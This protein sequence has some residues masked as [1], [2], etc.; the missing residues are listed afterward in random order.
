MSTTSPFGDEPKNTGSNGSSANIN[1]HR[2]HRERIHNSMIEA[3]KEMGTTAPAKR[4]TW[5]KAV[6]N[7]LRSIDGTY[8]LKSTQV[9]ND[10][11]VAPARRKPDSFTPRP[12]KHGTRHFTTPQ[13]NRGSV[14]AHAQVHSFRTPAR[15]QPHLARYSEFAQMQ[16]HARYSELAQMQPQEHASVYGQAQTSAYG[17]YQMDPVL[18]QGQARYTPAYERSSS[19][20]Q[21]NMPQV[22]RSLELKDPVLR[23]PHPL[24]VADRARTEP[25]TN[26]TTGFVASMTPQTQPPD[27]TDNDLQHQ[28]GEAGSK[29]D[30]ASD[31]SDQTEQKGTDA[32]QDYVPMASPAGETGENE[33]IKEM[34]REMRQENANRL[35]EMRQENANSRLREEE[36]RSQLANMQ[37]ELEMSQRQHALERSMS[38]DVEAE[39]ADG[40][41]QWMLNAELEADLQVD[42]LYYREDAKRL[43]DNVETRLRMRVYAHI[44][45]TVP[46]EFYSQLSYGD[47][48]GLYMSVKSLGSCD[49]AEQIMNLQMSVET[50]KKQGKPMSQWLDELYKLLE[51]LAV[52]DE[53]MELSRLRVYIMRNLQYDKRYERVATDVR[54][55]PGWDM[56]KIRQKLEAEAAY[57]KDLLPTA[58]NPRHQAHMGR[59]N[60]TELSEI[61]EVHAHYKALL[62]AQSAHPSGKPIGAAPAEGPTFTQAEIESHAATTCLDN[63]KGYCRRGDA[64]HRDHKMITGANLELVK[65]QVSLNYRNQKGG[66]GKGKG[67]GGKGRGGGGHDR[68]DAADS[69]S[70]CYSFGNNGVCSYGDNC[71]F[72]HDLPGAHVNMAKL[73]PV[74]AKPGDLIMIRMGCILQPLRG[75]MG[76]VASVIKNKAQ[77]AN[78]AQV[79]LILTDV[80]L[81]CSDKDRQMVEQWASMA[82]EIGITAAE[83]IICPKINAKVMLARNRA[84]ANDGGPYSLSGLFDTGAN[85]GISE[86]EKMIENLEALDELAIVD[87]LL[88]QVVATH[89]GFMSMKMGTDRVRFPCLLVKGSPHTIVPGK[90][91]GIGDYSFLGKDGGLQILKHD[92]IL[93]SFPRKMDMGS[94]SVYSEAFA[95]DIGTEGGEAYMHTLYPVPDSAFMTAAEAEQAP[96]YALVATR[97]QSLDLSVKT[98]GDSD[99]QQTKALGL[100][101]T[102]HQKTGHRSNEHNAFMHELITGK[103]ITQEEMRA[104]EPCVSCDIAKITSNPNQKERV[105]PLTKVG[106]DVATDMIVGMPRSL[107]GY[108]HAFHIHCM[109]SNY[110]TIIPLRTKDCG[111]HVMYWIKWLQ[112]RTGN[113]V[114][115]LHIDGGEAYTKKLAAFLADQGTEMVVNLANVHS[116]TTIERRHRDVNNIHNAQMHLGQAPSTLWEFSMPNA[117]HLINLNIPIRKLREMKKH[118]KALLRLT[119]RPLVPLEMVMGEINLRKIWSNLHTMFTLCVGKIETVY[120]EQHGAK[121]FQGVY[122]GT[123]QSSGNTTQYGHHMLRMHD[124]KVIAV[125]TVVT[126]ENTFPFAAKI[127]RTPTLPNPADSNSGGEELSVEYESAMDSIKGRIKAPEKFTPGTEAMTTA[128][129]CII[130]DRYDDGDYSATFPN[131][132]EPL[133]VRSVLAKDLWLAHEWPDWDHDSTGTRTSTEYTMT[134]TSALPT[135][136]RGTPH[137]HGRLSALAEAQAQL[138][139]IV[140]DE[141]NMDDEAKHNEGIGLRTT[142]SSTAKAAIKAAAKT[143]GSQYT[144][145]DPGRA[146]YVQPYNQQIKA[147]AMFTR[148]VLPEGT[149][150]QPTSASLKLQLACDVERILPK[151]WH[152]SHGHPYE[153]HLRKVEIKELQDCINRGVF[154]PPMDITPDMT[155]IGLMWVYAVKNDLGGL[156]TTFRARITLMGNQERLLIDK[157]MA[158]A[159]VAQSVMVRLL[160]VTHL[161]LPDIIFRQLDVSNAY[162]NEYMK[163]F[164]VC[165]MPPGYVIETAKDGSATFRTLRL[166]ERQPHQCCQVIKALYGGMECGR[167]FWESWV[168]WHLGRGFQIIHEERCYLHIRDGQGNWIKLCYHVDD[169]FIVAKGW[170]YYQAYL[171]DLSSKFDYTEGALESHLGVAYHHDPELG[172]MRIEQSAQT[173]KFLKEFKHDE[174]KPAA[175][176]TLA[177]P[178]P[179]KEDCLEPHVSEDAWD[180]E[181]FIGHANYLHMCTRPDIGQPLKIL[182]RFTKS[183]G[184][185]H[186]EYAKHL[187]RY[188][189][190]TVN[191]GLVYRTGYP[192]YYQIFTDASH[193]SCVDTR[194]SIISIVVKLGGNTVF[195][196]NSFTKI[197]SHSSTESELMALDV[198]ATIGQMLRWLVESIGGPVQGNIQIFVDNAGTISIASNPIQSGRNLHVHARYFYVRDLVYEDQFRIEKIPTELQ[199]ADIGCTFKGVK[200]FLDLRDCLLMCA[201]VIHDTNENPT[202]ET[203]Y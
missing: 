111:D 137:A 112:N 6:V 31:Q 46:K 19:L 65:Q 177:G 113:T 100:L 32:D 49:S 131:D 199:V 17:Q 128:G 170:D 85:I 105:I 135:G 164:V 37:A 179:C 184:K 161:H 159:P 58:P 142:R 38:Q 143:A 198:G 1:G 140:I 44:T 149:D 123:I 108:V 118:K 79:Q 186:V 99:T 23:T 53:P 47:V 63:I 151:H 155:I 174:C 25:R 28:G 26:I 129:P 156:F 62:L 152:Q 115:R 72:S 74:E 13:G 201:R 141:I 101:R 90:F 5:S 88:G 180:M 191:E 84:K 39:G 130:L 68:P 122:L 175:A 147:K 43:E 98:A 30:D 45:T 160:V 10:A 97:S 107:Q 21:L 8:M 36:T 165:R 9:S 24:G 59:H 48:L 93:A 194:R 154:G 116:N 153:Q 83:Y 34:F 77:G 87:A 27:H 71:K 127:Q 42:F 121:G 11:P 106:N 120:V 187:L 56:P 150:L 133:E 69:A 78:R 81:G 114:L 64:C 192:L 132:E 40:P 7:M 202:W 51:S 163:R 139:D 95:A 197:V 125:R 134:P 145:W 148:L 2:E 190:G 109:V 189:R 157:L 12:A 103:K 16:P 57:L 158:Y 20:E 181:G 22:A 185:R 136:T 169:N 91:L 94:D 162:I 144:V 203:R 119:D 193:A 76:Q 167:I 195:W 15:T 196:K 14:R 54:R 171:A 89:K 173:W 18:E 92:K 104:Q 166:G 75:A 60:H 146:Q 110:G 96:N 52:L 35:H 124:K 183:F 172:K 102:M 138:G 70:A 117:S 188:L 55:H 168:D 82:I 3:V 176:P 29:S 66:K 86:N 200:P 50:L 178:A 4:K 182:S 61:D 73:Q 67:K 33:Q 41:E 80:Y 126:Y